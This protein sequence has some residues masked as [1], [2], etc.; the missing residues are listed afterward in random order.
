MGALLRDLLVMYRV[1][2]R[3]EG[4]WHRQNA[5]ADGGTTDFGDVYDGRMEFGCEGVE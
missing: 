3:V 5:R 2:Y 4:E 1:V